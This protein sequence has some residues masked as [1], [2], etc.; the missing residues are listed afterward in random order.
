MSERLFICLKDLQI[1]YGVNKSTACKKLK[2][3]RDTL[4]KTKIQKV[5]FNELA[6]YEGV[7]V[8][9]IRNAIANT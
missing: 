2:I 3:I 8:S 1:L 5:T 9:E 4:N 6:N 7:D